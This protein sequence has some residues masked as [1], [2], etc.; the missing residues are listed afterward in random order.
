LG[1]Y[2]QPTYD[3]FIVGNGTASVPSNA[4]TLSN[5]GEAT[6]AGSVE[7]TSVILTS[8]NGTRFK[9]TIDDNGNP[10]STKI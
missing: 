9:I 1:Y 4:M 8:P 7:T 6:F 10:I 5:K 2:N 3:L